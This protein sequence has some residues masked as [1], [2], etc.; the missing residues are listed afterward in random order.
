MSARCTGLP[1]ADTPSGSLNMSRPRIA[2]QCVRHDERRRSQEPGFDLLDARGLGK[3]RLP[4]RM[5]T[6]NT[7]SR[8]IASAITGARGPELPMAGGAATAD[9]AEAERLQVLQQA[10]PAQ[11]G[12]RGRRARRQRRLFTQAEGLRPRRLALRATRPAATTSRT[13]VVLVQLVMAAIAT[14]VR[15][16]AA[17]ASPAGHIGFRTAALCC[18]EMRSCGRCGPAMLVETVSR[19]MFTMEVKCGSA[20]GSNH[21]PCA[22]A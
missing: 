1:S 22:F 5:A 8:V 10:G 12:L 16:M 2:E 18:G 14:G 21:R 19:S 3:L 11:I 7:G 13:S 9:N 17:G 6:G 4:D 20:S 15:G